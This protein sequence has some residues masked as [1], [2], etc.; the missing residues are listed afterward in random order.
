MSIQK[1][2]ERRQ[3]YPTL[4]AFLKNQDEWTM[5]DKFK[6]NKLAK[7]YWWLYLLTQSKKL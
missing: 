6:S 3:W 1:S 7:N 5:K 2:R 4:N